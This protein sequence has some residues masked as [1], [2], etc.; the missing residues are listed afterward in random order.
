M[1][2]IDEAK[3]LLMEARN[4]EA[5]ELLLG[6]A[7]SDPCNDE[8]YFE[9]GN[10]YRKTENFQQALNSYAEALEINP[11][12]PARQTYEMVIR[13]LDFYNKDMFNQ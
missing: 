8:A 3:A 12:S 10:A 7:E 11:E 5:I 4:E 6:L 2:K 9:L 13:I 1:N